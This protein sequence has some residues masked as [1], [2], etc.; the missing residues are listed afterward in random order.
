M[1]PRIAEVVM[2]K[3]DRIVFTSTIIKRKV[4][5]IAENF[6]HKKFFPVQVFFDGKGYI[7]TDGNH[8]TKALI[9]MGEPYIPA[10]LLTKEEFDHIKYSK[11]HVDILVKVPKLAKVYA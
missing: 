6:D 3:P 5:E 1:S 11:R 2:L 10:I 8:R 7:L 9:K 4:R